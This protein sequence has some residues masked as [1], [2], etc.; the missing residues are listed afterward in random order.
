MSYFM[1]TLMRAVLS[2]RRWML[3]TMVALASCALIAVFTSTSSATTGYYCGTPSSPYYL[4]INQDCIHGAYHSQIN[5]LTGSVDSGPL[6]VCVT[7]S[8]QLSNPGPNLYNCSNGAANALWQCGTPESYYGCNGYASIYNGSLA[9][10]A[11]VH[12]FMILP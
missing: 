12:G 10:G 3:L 7:V 9:G 1:E 8:S 11:Y 2:A 6:N 5:A 4:G